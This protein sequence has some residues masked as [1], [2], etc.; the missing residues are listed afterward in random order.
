ML[1]CQEL[2]SI[3]KRALCEEANLRQTIDNNSGGLNA[4]HRVEDELDG[5]AQLELRGIEQALLLIGIEQILRRLKLE[6]F[7]VRIQSPP[8]GGRSVK[9]LTFRLR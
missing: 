5:L 2:A 3:S 1:E 7:S 8:V 4:V 6:H 9:Q